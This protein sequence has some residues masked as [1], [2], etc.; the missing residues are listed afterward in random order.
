M[1]GL[2]SKRLRG[3]PSGQ[4]GGE[5]STEQVWTGP[6]LVTCHPSMDRQT[7]LKT[8]PYRI[9]FAYGNRWAIVLFF[10]ARLKTFGSGFFTTA[11]AITLHQFMLVGQTQPTRLIGTWNAS[12]WTFSRGVYSKI[13]GKC[14]IVAKEGSYVKG[15]AHLHSIKGKVDRK[16][17]QH[18]LWRSIRL[19]LIFRWQFQEQV[20][21][22]VME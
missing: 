20:P 5:S 1:C 4:G 2:H 14:P 13:Y 21:S 18:C 16:F 10:T 8:L 12:S 3:S 19:I 7:Q 11:D 6:W 22:H 9:S 17:H 15:V